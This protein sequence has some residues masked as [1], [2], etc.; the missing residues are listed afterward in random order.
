MKDLQKDKVWSSPQLTRYG[1]VSELTAEEVKDKNGT[2][3][4]QFTAQGLGIIGSY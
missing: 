2:A 3:Y 4:D 1:T